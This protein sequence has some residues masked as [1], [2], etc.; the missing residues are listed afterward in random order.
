MQRDG[1]REERRITLL[2]DTLSVSTLRI[3]LTHGCCRHVEAEP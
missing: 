3:R 1:E 2:L